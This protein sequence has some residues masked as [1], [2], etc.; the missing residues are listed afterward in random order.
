MTVPVS[1]IYVR[2]SNTAID[3]TGFGMNVA[4]VNCNANASIM[5]LSVNGNT[6]FRVDM[7]GNFGFQREVIWVP[8]RAMTPSL[9]NAPFFT[10]SE[11]ATSRVL[12]S[13][14]VFSATTTQSAQFDVLMPKSWNKAN[15]RYKLVVSPTSNGSSG[16]SNVSLWN[17]KAVSI[18]NLDNLADPIM[19]SNT[20]YSLV[21]NNSRH[22]Y[23]SDESS[24]MP[25]DGSP[26]EGDLVAFRISREASNASDTLTSTAKLLG[27]QVI[28]N[29][30]NRL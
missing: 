16:S 26:Q 19:S 27:V 6:V 10:Y 8:A 18:S 17:L 1:N 23:I 3:Y 29:P 15:I 7:D 9:T 22:L 5:K 2:F 20:Y 14:L 13:A 25:V 28:L 11:S 12:Q 21:A 4:N 30:T 24:Y